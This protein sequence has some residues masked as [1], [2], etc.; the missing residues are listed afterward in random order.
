MKSEYYLV[1]K[2]G[3]VATVWLNRPEKKNAMNPPAWTDSV[4]I[5]TEL[6]E[7]PEVRVIIIAAKGDDF[8]AGIDLFDMVNHLPELLNTEQKGGVKWPFLRKIHG[9]QDAMTVVE[10]IRKPVIAAVQG[11]CIGAGLDLISACDI[12]LATADAS[13]TLREAAMGMV[14]DMGVLQR[15]PHIVGQGITRELAYTA[16]FIDASRAREI[17]LI[18]E[19]FPDLDALMEGARKLAEEIANVAPLAV[20]ASKEVLGRAIAPQIDEGLRY[21]A[22]VSANIVP[23]NDLFEA[24]TALTEKRKPKYTGS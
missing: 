16:K 1:E 23:S 3:A 19:I 8:C 7:D 13:F 10:R 2:E 9:M 18:N 12:R 6:D 24:I 11:R 21:V 14:A 15:L 5:F 20:Q 4:G 17:H 22:S